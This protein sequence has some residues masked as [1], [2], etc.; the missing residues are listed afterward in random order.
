[1]DLFGRILTRASVFLAAGLIVL[2]AEWPALWPEF[3]LPLVV[4][5]GV[6]AAIVAWFGGAATILGAAPPG[7]SRSAAARLSSPGAFLIASAALFILLVDTRLGRWG[8]VILA[9]VLL[10]VFHQNLRFAAADPAS[11]RA[12]NL[13]NLACTLDAVG[14]FMFSAFLFGA[15]EFFEFPAVAGA[16][17]A[18]AAGAWIAYETVRRYGFDVR[19]EAPAVAFF[20]VLA[21]ELQGGLSFLPTV[22]EVNAAAAVLVAAPVLHFIVR[23]LA[24]R[25]EVRR[26]L[27][28]LAAAGILIAAVMLTARWR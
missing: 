10:W 11:E 12:R 16:A 15:S 13:N 24:G 6:L 7:F 8:I 20:G 21:A 9:A 14:G 18:G 22:R 17:L 23:I 1:M 28:I 26:T 27:R 3:G 2:E 25:M 4:A 5:S 19:K